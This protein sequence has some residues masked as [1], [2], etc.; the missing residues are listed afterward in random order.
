MPYQEDA[1]GRPVAG[2]REGLK[3]QQGNR[4]N[5]GLLQKRHAMAELLI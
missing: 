5:N 2:G 1:G 4:I 3:R